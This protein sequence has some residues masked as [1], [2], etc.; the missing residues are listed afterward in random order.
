MK[1]L[2]FILIALLIPVCEILSQS[3][4]SMLDVE[5]I[6]ENRINTITEWNH[7]YDGREPSD[8]GRI[9]LRAQ[10]DNYGYLREEIT[11]NS[12]GEKSRKV[13]NR[14]DSAGNRIEHIVFDSRSNRITFSQMAAFDQNGNKISEWGFDG[15]GDYRN[16]YHF[17]TEG[18]V[19]EIHY[20]SQGNLREKRI[21]KY[22][23]NETNV[24]VILPDNT[25][26]EKINL[27]YNNMGYL[28]QEAYFDNKGALV[29]KIE[30]TYNGSGQKTGK[31][32]YHRSQML[33]RYVYIYENGLLSKI[34]RNDRQ[35]RENVNNKYFYNENGQLVKEYWFNENADDYSTRK[36]TWDS[37]GNIVSVETYYASYNY[38]VLYRYDYSFF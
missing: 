17:D 26:L 31:R 34:I 6:K 32:R 7:T 38:Q 36:F 16:K 33:Y 5:L 4:I 13:T 10:Y 18:R 15:M 3:N 35:G 12:N 23:G 24:S 25:L 14:F 22:I 37:R 30:Y 9:S 19:R 20:T 2:L 1:K 27:K 21:F 28:I 11:F 8:D 29:R